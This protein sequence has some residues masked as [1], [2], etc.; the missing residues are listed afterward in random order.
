MITMIAFSYIMNEYLK[1]S[2]EEMDKIVK[3]I[4]VGNSDKVKCIDFMNFNQ[5]EKFGMVS[6]LTSSLV[7][8][9]NMWNIAVTIQERRES[10]G[11]RAVL[12]NQYIMSCEN[13]ATL[14]L[15]HLYK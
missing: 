4:D 15:S 13:A 12:F 6:K 5:V 14:P 3:E 11:K 10:K 9:E 1:L 8:N 7:S 2:N